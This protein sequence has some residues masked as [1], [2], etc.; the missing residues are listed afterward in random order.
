M[1]VCYNI[2]THP[3]RVKEVYE[4][5]LRGGVS[6]EDIVWVLGRLLPTQ[7]LY[8]IGPRAGLHTLH[9]GAILVGLPGWTDDQEDS[10]M[11]AITVHVVTSL[12][13]NRSCCI[14]RRLRGKGV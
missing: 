4:G 5:L 2:I 8:L 12:K 7:R 6:P 13:Q 9:R 1:N 10:K 3:F 14:Y 11:F